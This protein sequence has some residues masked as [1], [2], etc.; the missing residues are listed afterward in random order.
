MNRPSPFGG[1]GGRPPGRSLPY[2]I[3]RRRS[4]SATAAVRSEAPSFSKM[5]SRCVLTVSGEMFSTLAFACF[6]PVDLLPIPGVDRSD[7]Q[8]LS[9]LRLIRIGCAP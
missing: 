1:F 8:I 4:A 9:E 5:C 7:V 6:E 3:S 2:S